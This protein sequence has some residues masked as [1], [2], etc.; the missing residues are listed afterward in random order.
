MAKN[1][2]GSLRNISGLDNKKN[3]M[4]SRKFMREYNKAVI[5]SNEDTQF[6][7]KKTFSPSTIGYGHGK[8]ARYWHLAFGGAEFKKSVTVAGQSAMSNGTDSHHRIQKALAKTKFFKE[9]ERPIRSTNPP[10][11]GYADIILESDGKEIVGEIK[12]IKSTSFD[13]VKLLNTG[14]DYHTLQILIY[15]KVVGTD[16]G[17][18]LY[19]N[20]DTHEIL[21]LPVNMSQKNEEY[22]NRV[23]DWMTEVYTS[24]KNGNV[25]ERGFNKS[26]YI[27][28]YC[29]LSDF[30]NND[31]RPTNIKIESLKIDG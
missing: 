15:M 5:G 1:L 30:C 26:D 10:I 21:Y 25:A 19:E 28:K 17:F 4:T 7:T 20:K 6:M 23:F 27:C 3:V 22:V 2:I 16:E 9:E 31:T 12:T 14:I 11:L 8:C 29:P 13:N 18:L 24:W